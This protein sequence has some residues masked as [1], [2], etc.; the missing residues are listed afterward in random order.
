MNHFKA[1]RLIAIDSCDSIRKR[2]EEEKQEIL[3][4]KAAK[5]EDEKLFQD[6]VLADREAEKEAREKFKKEAIVAVASDRTSYKDKLGENIE[7]RNK[8]REKIILRN[9]KM[10]LLMDILGQDKIDLNAL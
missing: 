6:Q 2:G 1:E 4:S 3:D 10:R 8:Y 5:R 7:A 9:E